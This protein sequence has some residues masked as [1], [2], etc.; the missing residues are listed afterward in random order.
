[1]PDEH[2]NRVDPERLQLSRTV[3]QVVKQAA[4]ILQQELT[5]GSGRATTMQT[6]YAATKK[7]DPNEFQLLSSRVRK[8]VHDLIAMAAEMFSELTTNEVQSLV[9]RMATDAHDVIDTTMNLV[10]NTPATAKTL[11]NLGFTTP[12]PAGP[13]PATGDTPTPDPAPDSDD[14]PLRPSD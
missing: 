10:E 7:V 5:D 8:D 13:T 1:M 6:K 9:S 11:A 12:P 4:T 2:L 14:E 3:S